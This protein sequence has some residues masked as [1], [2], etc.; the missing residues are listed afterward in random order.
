MEQRSYK[1]EMVAS[2]GYSH[3]I[4]TSERYRYPYAIAKKRTTIGKV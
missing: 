3:C 1:K 4:P 2:G